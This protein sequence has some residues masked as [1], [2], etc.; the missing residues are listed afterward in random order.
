[1]NKFTVVISCDCFKKRSIK[2][3]PNKRGS[4]NLSHTQNFYKNGILM[5]SYE[6]ELPYV[7][8]CPF[9][10]KKIQMGYDVETVEL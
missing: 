8:Y 2:V 4:F 9:C 3:I 1:M 10:G 5:S 6:N 7:T